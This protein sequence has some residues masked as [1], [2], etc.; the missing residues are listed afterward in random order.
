MTVPFLAPLGAGLIAA[1]AYDL[2]RRRVPNWV[3]GWV[4]VSAL[5][6]R[7]IEQGP[8][9][10]PS[11]LA[12]AGLI[13]GLLFIPWRVGGI[14]GGD[15]KLAAATAAWLPFSLLPWF[16]LATALA[17]GLV[18]LACYAAER[19]A[20]RA[21]VRA[22]LTIAWLHGSLPSITPRRAGHVRVPYA[23][24]IAAG[25]VATFVFA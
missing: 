2:L 10:V 19:P 11:A 23:L 7:G 18:A 25:A 17:G 16:A 8:L 22:N 5:V 3:C 9:A 24:A 4:L 20:A 12:A 1:T 6:V 21:E 14:G 15:V 13:L